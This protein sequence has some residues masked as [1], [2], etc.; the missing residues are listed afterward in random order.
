MT[1][2]LLSLF[3]SLCAI[4]S[5][6]TA[7]IGVFPPPAN[8]SD[9]I[10]QL[11]GDVTAGPGSGSQP[12]TIS[13]NAVKYSMLKQSSANAWL[14]WPGDGSLGAGNCSTAQAPGEYWYS[15]FTVTL[16]NTCSTSGVGPLII[17]ATGVCTIAGT[18][19]NNATNN[20]GSAEWGGS[21]GGGGFG[22][23]NGTAG[24]SITYGTITTMRAGGAA[25]TSGNPGGTGGT[26]STA[27]QSVL[28]SGASMG[29]L[30]GGSG[31]GAGG[32]SGGVGGNGGGTI[33][34]VCGSI[35]FTG[36]ISANGGNGV[37][38]GSNTGGG[39]GGGGGI[40]ITAT[41]TYAANTGTLSVTSGSGG[42]IGTGTSTAG[43]AGGA[44][45]TKQITIQ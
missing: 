20:S 16:G 42:L 30:R 18:L 41:P 14:T 8:G 26:T 15:S 17:R 4:A 33:V 10:N 5:A 28:L 24:G 27:Q 36:T 12:S 34:L 44:G 37:N 9:G 45:W 35:N 40:V 32:S 7:G 13:P 3:F 22:A 38:G 39:G 31:G 23:A 2:L 11:T 25:G 21:G 19:S 29:W 6:Q 43:G 1:R